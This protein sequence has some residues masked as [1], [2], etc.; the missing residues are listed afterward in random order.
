MKNVIYS[1][2]LVF[3]SLVLWKCKTDKTPQAPPKIVSKA[4]PIV[5]LADGFQIDSVAVGLKRLVIFDLANN[6]DTLSVFWLVDQNNFHGKIPS[7]KI[8]EIPISSVACRSTT[9]L[10]FFTFLDALSCV[11]AVSYANYANNPEVKAKVKAGN[12]KNL[13]TG[14]EID[15]EVLASVNTKLF[16]TYPFGNVNENRMEDLGITNLP[17]LE[18][19]ENTPLKREEWIKLFGA[20]LGKESEAKKVFENSLKTYKR[21]ADNIK[22]KV[23]LENYPKVFTGSLASG[24]WSAPSGKSLIATF[25]KDAGGKY[26]FE[27]NKKKGNITLEYE[28]FYAKALDADYWGKVIYSSDEVTFSSLLGGDERLEALKAVKN[29]NIFYCNATQTDYFGDAVLQPEVILQDLVNIFH[30]EMKK[31]PNVYFKLIAP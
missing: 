24:K 21:L 14:D 8:I 19:L 17:I 16:T 30:P 7:G 15:L 1:V 27:N 20:L 25:I 18:Y 31:S 6:R 2:L 26:V 22:E 4:R 11:K 13:T 9:H 29:K 23:P 28:A 12:I 3:I 10:P 5:Q